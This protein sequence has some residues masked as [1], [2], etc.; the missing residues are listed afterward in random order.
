ML[1]NKSGSQFFVD[2]GADSGFE[3]LSQGNVG[4]D[5]IAVVNIFDVGFLLLMDPSKCVK[6][7]QSLT[8]SQHGLVR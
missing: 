8:F 7:G 5:E 2:F 6:S 1:L 4:S 3:C